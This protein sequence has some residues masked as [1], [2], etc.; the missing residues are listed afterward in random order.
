MSSHHCMVSDTSATGCTRSK[1]LRSERDVG[2]KNNCIVSIKNIV[3]IISYCDFLLSLKY[4]GYF[5]WNKMLT[6]GFYFMTG[7]SG[8]CMRWY[9]CGTSGA[10]YDSSDDTGKHSSH[11]HL[12]LFHLI[13]SILSYPGKWIHE[14][15]A[16]RPDLHSESAL[17][18][19][20]QH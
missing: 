13:L 16:F 4:S 2:V 14:W 6:H 9:N 19:S 8:D 10:R 12:I 3:S 17:D 20:V 15:E 18:I 1:S 7:F 11:S 5:K